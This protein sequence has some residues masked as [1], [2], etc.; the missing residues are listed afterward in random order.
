MRTDAPG[1][2]V[3]CVGLSIA[4]I[5]LA[6]TWVFNFQ[7]QSAVLSRPIQLGQLKRRTHRWSIACTVLGTISV[8]G[9]PVLVRDALL[10]IHIS[11]VL[12]CVDAVVCGEYD[13]GDIQ[14]FFST[15]SY[16]SLHN[17]AAY[18]FFFL[19]TIA[20]FINVR[21]CLLQNAACVRS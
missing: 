2:Y 7:F 21:T 19:E 4:A 12:V 13:N 1:Y 5:A 18:W 15:S 8:I 3:F 10:C 6:L 14:A 11:A 16:P 17:Y 20:I 9:L